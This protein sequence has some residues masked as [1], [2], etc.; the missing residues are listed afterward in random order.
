MA[1][2]LR[3]VCVL[4]L[5]KNMAYLVSEINAPVIM[6]MFLRSNHQDSPDKTSVKK[7]LTAKGGTE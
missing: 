1:P 2:Y 4:S 6:M 5:S 3:S 7:T